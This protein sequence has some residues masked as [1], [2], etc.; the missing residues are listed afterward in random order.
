MDNISNISSEEELLQLRNDGKI[1]ETEYQDL[2]EAMR[3]TSLGGDEKLASGMEKTQSKQKLG[4]IALVL[5]FLGIIIPIALYMIS[6][7]ALWPKF[8]LCLTLEIAAFVMGIISWPNVYGKA[9]VI[10]ISGITLVIVSVILLYYALAIKS[11]NAR[12][13]MAMAELQQ[14]REKAPKL[15]SNMAEVSELKS[16]PLDDMEGLITRSGV[17]IDKLISNDGNGSLRIDINKSANIHLFETGDIDVE[18]ARL[19]Y[20]AKLRTE[21]VQGE[22]YLEMWCH[23]PGK[24]EF[25]SKGFSQVKSLT[26]T[27]E[28]IT[29]EIAFLL[30]KGENPDNV[31]LNL[32][33]NGNGTVW[34][35]DI[36]LLKSILQ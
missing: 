30:R 20:Q 18:N 1:S 26:G 5:M 29:E 34:I 6:G 10:T 2:L 17:R 23:F 27:K 35:D 9:A 12:R 7:L 19:F 4:K 36:R 16:Y 25:F 28:W 22:V 3:K 32:V 15:L 33:I 8:F 31:K 24:G 21:K 11:E 13:D 14:A